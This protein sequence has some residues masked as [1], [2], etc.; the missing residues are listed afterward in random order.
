[1]KSDFMLDE[2]NSRVKNFGNF[3]EIAK[4]INLDKYKE[5]TNKKSFT[6]STISKLIGALAMFVLVITSTVLIT[7][8][9]S[10]Y[11]IIDVS[12][13]DV[14]ASIN[15]NHNWEIIYEEKEDQCVELPKWNDRS[16]IQKY[17]YFKY[18]KLSYDIWSTTSSKPIL[19]KYIEKEIDSILITGYDVYEDSTHEI[20]ANVYKIRKI[21][22]DCAIGIQFEGDNKFYAYINNFY[23]FNSLED[24]ITKLNLIEYSCFKNA[25]Y[26]FED[27]DGTHLIRFD[28]F[29][30]ELVWKELLNQAKNE[31]LFLNNMTSSIES[32]MSI[33][34]NIEA[35]GIEG[36][37]S[38]I[39]LDNNG[40]MEVHIL[41][42]NK[43]KSIF[44]LDVESI[45]T[46][47]KYLIDNIKGYEIIYIENK[48][49]STD[50]EVHQTSSERL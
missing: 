40:F 2:I 39:G 15:E 21:D 31:N 1:M 17:S 7:K 14:G 49:S 36:S 23:K 11:K 42:S 10:N 28:D 27:K 26:E 9:N 29:D 43:S 46:F 3:S 6:S 45:D 50:N 37:A 13:S 4:R 5:K 34:V 12:T 47:S 24:I 16:L 19:E 30:D 48:D 35:L 38:W 44:K 32:F 8:I 25:Y 33:R 20:K 22:M 41:S 18:N